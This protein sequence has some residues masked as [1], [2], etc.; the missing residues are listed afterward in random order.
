[1]TEKK[2]IKTLD[3]ALDYIDELEKAL[4]DAIEVVMKRDDQLSATEKRI[5]ELEFKLENMEEPGA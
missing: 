1:M 4:R 2:E 5:V 3:E